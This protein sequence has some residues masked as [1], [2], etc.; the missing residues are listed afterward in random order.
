MN[1]T[2]KKY[3]RGGKVPPILKY[4]KEDTFD[5]PNSTFVNIPKFNANLAPYYDYNNNFGNTLNTTLNNNA[6]VVDPI[7]DYILN[8]LKNRQNKR[9]KDATRP[10]TVGDFDRGSKYK[11]QEGVE[12]TTDK[13]IQG[14]SDVV[15]T[16]L[17]FAAMN[18]SSKINKDGT[19][20]NQDAFFKGAGAGAGVGGS[21]GSAIGTA[22][23]P[24]VGTA[25]GGAI[26]TGVGALSG[27]LINRSSNK[28]RNKQIEAENAKAQ[29]E[30]D[31]INKQI[32]RQR[33]VDLLSQYNSTN[34]N[35]NILKY[36]G[37]IYAANGGQ[38]NQIT[39]TTAIA[40]GN[41]HAE[42]GIELSNGDLNNVGINNGNYSPVEVE[43][44]EIIYDAPNGNKRIL[45]DKLGFSE[46][47]KQYMNSPTFKKLSN[48]YDIQLSKLN[49]QESTYKKKLS[50]N[51]FDNLNKNTYT[52]KI[53]NVAN[54]RSLLK[55]PLDDIY[56]MQEVSK[57]QTNNTGYA[58]FGKELVNKG[59]SSL[60]QDIDITDD[61]N[62]FLQ[63]NIQA[64]YA[65]QSN[66]QNTNLN[67]NKLDYYQN[68]M[69]PKNNF[70]ISNFNP[71]TSN[72]KLQPR[73]LNLNTPENKTIGY[74]GD[75]YLKSF[76]TNNVLG[77][78]NYNENIVNNVDTTTENTKKNYNWN[79]G[80]DTFKKGVTAIS[81]Y[82][83]NYYNMKLI[84]RMQAPNQPK[85][86][87]PEQL[88]TQVDINDQL[89]DIQGNASKISN[90]MDVNS[91]NSA[92]S[93]ASKARIQSNAMDNINKAYANKNQLE[94]SLINQ[95]KLNRQGIN[96]ANTQSLNTYKDAL[97]DFRNKQAM[98]KSQNISNAVEDYR[99]QVAEKNIEKLDNQK[100][101]VDAIKNGDTN[102]AVNLAMYGDVYDDK[103]IDTIIG[104]A[105][106]DPSRK[107]E[108]AMLKRKYN[109]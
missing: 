33:S 106:K 95:N 14:I 37:Q 35:V 74:Y 41:T 46:L 22:I 31:S 65:T 59:F 75:N 91:S 92:I 96:A 57:G 13:K 55:H 34:P 58:K 39:P 9:Y 105:S 86:L 47:A 70:D 90:Y 68:Y 10:M 12:L 40:N 94:T 5:L 81:P 7:N 19:I 36:G 43:D 42:G 38:V 27:G 72:F 20:N 82:V 93:R 49:K 3:K 83:D 87:T 44:N 6:P 60:N 69:K 56:T 64:P 26:G 25:I 104:L 97:G 67:N 54:Q 103:T 109:R 8:E 23:L 85:L 30:L 53:Q 98:L 71:K 61:N 88:K 108:V 84:D 21:L 24:G 50:E 66:I 99:S 80:F 32:D 78:N 79:K 16:G 77:S 63:N 101:V 28:K 48:A 45:S 107:K 76:N 4:E 2:I 73:N 11:A 52:R 102:V 18:A 89:Q 17:Q 100:L 15:G 51:K 1:K 29:A 62:M